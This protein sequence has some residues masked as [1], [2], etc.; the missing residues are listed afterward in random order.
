MKGKTHEVRQKRDKSKLTIT[1]SKEELRKM[2]RAARRKAELEQGTFVRGGIHG[3]D[4]HD[5]NKRDR[6]DARQQA[7]NYRDG[8][9]DE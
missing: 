4:K 1:I 6:R 3:G 9:Y 8:G 7:R 2:D 5:R